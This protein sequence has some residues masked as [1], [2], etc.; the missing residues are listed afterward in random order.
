[1]SQDRTQ[2]LS[3]E[4]L[5]ALPQA[6]VVIDDRRR[7]VMTNLAADTL[8]TSGE[9]HLAPGD[10][11]FAH[12]SLLSE[13]GHLLAA[14]GLSADQTVSD[15]RQAIET[16][17]PGYDCLFAD[18]RA[19]TGQVSPMSEGR[20]LLTLTASDH[21]SSQ[22]Q[23]FQRIEDA[24][25]GSGI[26]L[27]IFD[28][29]LTIR[30][31]NDAWQSMTAPVSAGASARLHAEALIRD[32]KIPNPSHLSPESLADQLINQVFVGSVEIEGRHPNGRVVQYRG[33]RLSLGGIFALC[34]DVTEMRAAEIKARELL[35]EM[36]DALEEGVGLYDKDLILRISN[37]A[38]HRHAHTDHAP[39]PVGTS[40]MDHC[41]YVLELGTIALPEGVTGD[42][43]TEM[44]RG[45]VLSHAEGVEV[46]MS[47]GRCIEL[48]SFPT[49]AGGHL[50]TMRDAT[51]RKAAEQ[52]EAELRRERERAFQNEKL[53]S[54]GEMLSGIAHE[55]N[56]P[57]AV[58]HGY[59]QMISERVAGTEL[60]G[61]AQ[62]LR[63]AADRCVRIVRTFLAMA[64]QKP[65]APRLTDISGTL[66]SAI[67]LFHLSDREFEVQID[68][69]VEPLELLIDEDQI[70]QVCLNLIENAAQA[71]SDAGILPPR[72]VIAMQRQDGS[73]DILFRDSGPGVHRDH[74]ARIFEPFFTT[75]D[76][77]RGSGIG[78]AFS[79]R[80]VT[81]HGGRLSLNETGESGSTFCVSL[82]IP[83]TER[84]EA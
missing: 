37:R 58:V 23:L 68:L 47:D 66:R 67:E 42:M 18:G 51:S 7:V 52:A 76:Q 9:I 77:G 15:I 25:A 70:L 44:V 16:F 79:H 72:L 40:L 60:A 73:L 30:M 22:T 39:L 69:D 84:L 55:L 29:T 83:S 8:L 21:S 4:T 17:R 26:G 54:L 49:H 35:E 5:D 75:K 12:L 65:I 82:P 32:R 1:M 10:D 28:E 71:M 59:S 57:L 3:V 78:L 14:P 6:V 56:N 33:F 20:R 62:E 19:F 11:I 13:S 45:A 2:T 61:S 81:A 38:L 43:F 31:V 63:M 24:L 74:V 53:S 46:P 48:S 41:A 64:R 34:F 36:V 80:I 50:V 27:L